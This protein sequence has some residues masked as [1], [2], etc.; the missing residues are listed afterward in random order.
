MDTKQLAAKAANAISDLVLEDEYT[1]DIDQVVGG[2]DDD[3]KFTMEKLL[4]INTKLVYE[5]TV[6]AK[7]VNLDDE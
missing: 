2:L 1:V 5:V 4:T 6:T 3:G 7:V